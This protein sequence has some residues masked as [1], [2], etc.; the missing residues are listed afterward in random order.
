MVRTLALIIIVCTLPLRAVDRNPAG[1]ERVLLP[2]VLDSGGRPGAHGAVWTTDVHIRNESAAMVHIFEFGCAFFCTCVAFECETR[3]TNPGQIYVPGSGTNTIDR[4]NVGRLIYVGRD[5]ANDVPMNLRIR[6]VSRSATNFGTEVPVVREADLHIDTPIRL[7]GVPIEPLF[8]QHLRV[9]GISSP[10]GT[11]VLRVRVFD[12]DSDVVLGERELLL[13]PGIGKNI[14]RDDELVGYP[15]YDEV[16][17]LRVL[18]P[19]GFVGRVRV[20][21]S[22]LTSGLKYWAMVSVTNNETQHVTLVTPQ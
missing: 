10:S 2:V 12:R 18:V 5:N 4:R 14:A 6:D 15:S 20:E 17:D 3:P 7:L 19:V 16:S 11:G 13:T 22:S 9:Y 21:V 1:Y 8:R